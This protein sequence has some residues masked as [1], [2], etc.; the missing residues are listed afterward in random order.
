MAIQLAALAGARPVAVVSDDSKAAFVKSLGAVGVINRSRFS[1]WGAPPALD[2]GA[3]YASYIENVKKFGKAIWNA[4]GEKRD[5]DMVFEH[6]GRD[7]FA[8]SCY[9]VKRGGMVVFCAATSGYELACDARYIWMR[10]K[11]IQGSHFATLKEAAQAN[12][13]VMSGRIDPCLSEVFPWNRL[14][15]AHARIRTNQHLPGNMAVL[16][17]ASNLDDVAAASRP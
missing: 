8:A 17:Q 16:V 3:Q 11:R 13:L 1:C 10:Q 14:P 2:S 15:D 4:L 9:V 5:V 6:P 7:T 12:R